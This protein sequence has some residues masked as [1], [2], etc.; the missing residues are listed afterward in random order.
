MASKFRVQRMGPLVALLSMAVGMSFGS[1]SRA[2]DAPVQPAL[3]EIIVTA[4]Q[5]NSCRTPA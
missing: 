3:M 1:P 4:C 2:D 5:R